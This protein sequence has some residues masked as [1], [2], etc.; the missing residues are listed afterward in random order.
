MGN[1]VIEIRLLV[2]SLIQSADVFCIMLDW[3]YVYAYWKA[4]YDSKTKS[5]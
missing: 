3:L 1:Y 4:K 2:R 5:V